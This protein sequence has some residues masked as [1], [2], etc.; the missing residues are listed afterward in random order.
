MH[1]CKH[2]L[3]PCIFYCNRIFSGR[4]C[5]E[6]YW[7]Q[8]ISYKIKSKNGRTLFL[9]TFYFKE[10]FSTGLFLVPFMILFPRNFFQITFLAVTAPKSFLG[11]FELPQQVWVRS[12]QPF[13]SLLDT[14]QSNSHKGFFCDKLSIEL[15]LIMF[16]TILSPYSTYCLLCTIT[17]YCVLNILTSGTLSIRRS[18]CVLCTI[19]S[20]TLGTIVSEDLVAYCVVCTLIYCT[21]GTKVSENIVEYCVL[22]IL[23]FRNYSIWE[24]CCVL[25]TVYPV[26]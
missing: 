15:F 16:I 1:G 19:Y 7:N 25:C 6:S 13:W 9:E 14:K 3:F 5:I 12:V 4:F 26:L 21:L 2:P 24:P 23:Y 8:K 10:C 11:S 22:Y 17:V 18:C 20:C